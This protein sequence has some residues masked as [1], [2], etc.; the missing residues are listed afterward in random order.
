MRLYGAW[1]S[2]D[3]GLPVVR[4]RGSDRPLTGGQGIGTRADRARAV[5]PAGRAAGRAEAAYNR[6]GGVFAIP[7]AMWP[8]QGWRQP[9]MNRPGIRGGT[10][11]GPPRPP[12]LHVVHADGH[13]LV[14]AGQDLRLAGGV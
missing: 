1:G 12:L 8:P 7:I 9:V 10:C 6:H 11:L 4:V 3:S 2:E 13:G 5:R 14:D